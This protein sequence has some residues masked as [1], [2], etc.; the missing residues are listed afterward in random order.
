[1]DREEVINMGG[2]T[3]LQPGIQCLVQI[4]GLTLTLLRWLLVGQTRW[5]SHS[6]R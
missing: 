5:C 6:N 3:H 1:M 2:G 4:L